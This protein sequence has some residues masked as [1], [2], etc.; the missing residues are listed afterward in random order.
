[1]VFFNQSALVG[2]WRAQVR[3]CEEQDIALELPDDLPCL[4]WSCG[5]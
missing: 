1:M 4:P 3:R 5:Y 2:E